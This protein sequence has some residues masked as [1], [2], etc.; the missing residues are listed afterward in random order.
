MLMT[1]ILD[2]YKKSEKPRQFWNEFVSSP[3]S[4]DD[5]I[6]EELIGYI[7]KQ[8]KENLEKL[9]VFLPEIGYVFANEQINAINQNKIEELIKVVNKYGVIPK[10]FLKFYEIVGSVDLRGFFP[11]WK[12]N[13]DIPVLDPLLILPINDVLDYTKWHLKHNEN[14]FIDE[15]N[16]PYLWFSYDELTKDGISGDG[17]YGIELKAIYCIDGNVANYGIDLQFIDYLRLCFKWAGFPNLH[18]FQDEL[19][20]DELFQEIKKIGSRLNSF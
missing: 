5:K 6:T 8:V 1:Q 17:G 11:E 2:N 14:I 15:K 3:N 7:M 16:N 4:K 10:S 13:K 19:K 18:W 20:D 9:Q 12:N